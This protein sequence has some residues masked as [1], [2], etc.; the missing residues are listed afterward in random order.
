MSTR[1]RIATPTRRAE[2][3]SGFEAR[4]L[5]ESIY[6]RVTS[7]LMAVVM[8]A[9][10]VVGLMGLIYMTNQAYASRVTAPLQIVEVSEGAE[11][12]PRARPARPRRSTS[13]GPTPRPWPRTTRKRRATSRSRRC[14]RPPGAMLDAVAEAGSGLAE[15]DLGPVMPIGRA[16]RQRQAVVQAGH[17]GAR[18]RLRPRRRRR[19]PRTALEHHLQHRADPRG[20]CP[21]AR[22]PRR[23][24]GRGQR[25]RPARL[26]LQLLQPRADQALRLGAERRPALFPLAGQGPEGVGPRPA[27]RKAGIDVGERWCS[28]S[29]PRASRSSSPSSRCATR[30]GS[31]ARSGSP[32]SA[33]SPRGAV[34]ASRSSPRRRC[35]DPIC[36]SRRVSPAVRRTLPRSRTRS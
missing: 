28:S 9:L 8:G 11:A 10:M 18:A 33:S 20:I 19:G 4:I 26:R 29:I 21:P 25:A 3:P 35:V 34:T 12:V 32:G 2:K 13:P 22:C 23:R 6:D 14:R 16:G 24:A 15:V 36:S 17:R 31:P 5:G 1:P 27:C 30:A 7:L